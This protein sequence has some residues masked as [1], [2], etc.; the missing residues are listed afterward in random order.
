MNNKTLKVFLLHL[1]LMPF[2][3]NS[4]NVIKRVFLK[5]TVQNFSNQ[6]FIS[7]LS[8]M[9]N[10]T[11]QNIN[12]IIIPDSLG[13]FEIN[14]ELSKPNYFKIGRNTLYLVPGDKL[15]MILDYNYAENAV[16]MSSSKSVKDVNDYLKSTPFYNGGSF[17]EAGSVIKETIQLT[18]DAIFA[19]AKKRIDTLS[20]YTNFSTKFRNLEKARITADIINSLFYIPAYFPYMHKMPVD[21]IP[22]FMKSYKEI[23]APYIA[24]YSRN[25]IKP[26]YLTLEIFRRVVF[27]LS[28]DSVIRKSFPKEISDWLTAELLSVKIRSEKQK[29]KLYGFLPEIK[30]IKS[31]KYKQALLEKINTLTAFNDGDFARNIFFNDS[32]NHQIGL[33][34]FKGKVIFI[35][36]WA[37]WCGPCFDE[38]P[39]LD[40]LRNRYKEDTG[41]V[42]ISLSI[43]ENKEL[44]K[45]VLQKGNLKGHQFLASKGVLKEYNVIYVPRVIIIDK[46]FVVAA[47]NG[48]SPSSSDTE[49]FL[50][51]LLK[52]EPVKN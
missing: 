6:I 48:P 18:I 11:T 46:N 21:S 40:T 34:Q 12:R 27:W 43:D 32:N 50:N 42:F 10:L 8:D 44:W 24:R 33:N 29:E 2:L 36:I 22:S 14:F 25:F 9:K 16:F 17:L 13:N 38:M 23:S 3:L 15:S 52:N 30:K 5:G 35:D 31:N 19:S 49:I 1:F 20:R 51:S 47:M 4:Q 39:F 7:D 26:E 37:T 41:I 45:S 28:E